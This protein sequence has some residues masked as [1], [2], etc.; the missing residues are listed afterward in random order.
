MKE[1][2][3]LNVQQPIIVSME[4]FQEQDS[5]WSLR[6]IL[7]INFRICKFNPIKA[8]SYIP[9]PD[10]IAK[11]KA[12]INIVNTDNQCFKWAL[13]SA[14]HP[15]QYNYNQVS[16]YI[17]YEHELNFKGIQ[18]PVDPKQITKFEKQNTVS[19]N[20][21]FLKKGGNVYTVLPRHLTSQKKNKHVNLLL[22]ESYY[23][24]E[25][26]AEVSVDNV[27]ESLQFHY[28]WIKDLSRE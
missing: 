14:L 20:V 10:F 4:D 5:G 28:V 7:N 19:V 24:D 3:D 11:K 23:V 16:S 27:P 18:F 22:I 13:L 25:N 26:D 6:S 2:F 15:V 12:C 17:Q 1:W 8:S 21:Y 9:L